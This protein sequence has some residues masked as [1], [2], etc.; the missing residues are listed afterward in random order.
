MQKSVARV[1][2]WRHIWNNIEICGKQKEKK[3]E[4]EL[5]KTAYFSHFTNTT[6]SDFKLLMLI[7]TSSQKNICTTYYA[8]FFVIRNF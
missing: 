8:I 3:E 6:H 5:Y 1:L 7:F 2:C 4:K